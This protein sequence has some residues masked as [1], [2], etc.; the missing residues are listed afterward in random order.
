MAQAGDV[1]PVHRIGAHES[2]QFEEAVVCLSDLLQEPQQQ[3]SD[4]RDGDLDAHGI[5]G[6]P[7]EFADF[8]RNLV[9]TANLVRVSAGPCWPRA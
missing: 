6:A 2:N 9:R 3:E 8:G 4:Q 5:A 7:D 1:F